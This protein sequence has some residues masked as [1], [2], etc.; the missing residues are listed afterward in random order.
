[1]DFR[2]GR[3]FFFA[4]GWRAFFSSLSACRCDLSDFVRFS[5]M[6]RVSHRPA[7]IT[8]PVDFKLHHYLITSTIETA[9]QFGVT[10]NKF[11]TV[12]YRHAPSSELE[13]CCV[14]RDTIR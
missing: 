11:K 7:R 10:R 12:R 2:D 3:F 4:P 9:R 1:M 6:L 14:N 8:M 13:T 5:D